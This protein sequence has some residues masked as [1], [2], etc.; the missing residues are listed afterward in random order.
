[1]A[2]V[3]YWQTEKYEYVTK[4]NENE[5]ISRLKTKTTMLLPSEKSINNGRLITLAK[6][7]VIVLWKSINKN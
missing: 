6:N 5:E 4:N 2:L 7:Y 1:M 3:F